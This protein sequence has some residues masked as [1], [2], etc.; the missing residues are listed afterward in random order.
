MA[1]T[2]QS[3]YD[4]MVAEGISEATYQG[5]DD[6]LAMFNNPSATALW[7]LL[8]N[9]QAVSIASMENNYDLFTAFVNDAL[10]NESAHTTRWYRTKALAFQYGFNLI[11][12]TDQFD[13]T[14]YTDD[15]IAASQIVEYAA[16]NETTVDSKRVL[17]IK[18]ATLVNGDLAPLSDVQLAAFTAYM[19][20]IKDAG[21]PLTI[22]NQTAALITAQVDYYYNPLLLDGNGNRLDGLGEPPVPAA[23]LNYLLNLPFNGEFSN[24]K[25]I[26][27]LQVSFGNGD[28]NVFLKSAQYKTGANSYTA[29]PN[30]FVPDAGYVRF[31]TDGLVIN[32]IP[33]VAG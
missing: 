14:G 28:G 23:A 2:I 8:F 6:A 27:A 11:P 29:I 31:D 15:E 22:Y 7:K 32:Y 4:S 17:L 30:T 26:D 21:V 20:E 5:N 10:A 18:I 13:N 3:I 9:T 33:Y 19:Q 25:F 12:D 1:D 16:V 24:A